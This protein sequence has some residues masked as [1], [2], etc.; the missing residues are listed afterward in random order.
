MALV[1]FSFL[2]ASMLITVSHGEV[3][4]MKI[5]IG[6]PLIAVVSH[7]PQNPHFIAATSL[8]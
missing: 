4:S 6:L 8:Y 7:D 1:I 5:P 3:I 2:Y